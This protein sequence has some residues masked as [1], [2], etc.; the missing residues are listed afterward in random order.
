MWEWTMGKFSVVWIR[1]ARHI[2][3]PR[4]LPRRIPFSK[5]QPCKMPKLVIRWQKW[6]FQECTLNLA[7]P[8]LLYQAVRSETNLG[9]LHERQQRAL[10]PAQN[11]SL[12]IRALG[13][14]AEEQLSSARRQKP[15]CR[16][17]GR[18]SI[19]LLTGSGWGS[20]MSCFQA[21]GR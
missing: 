20:G 21:S 8:G 5:S 3:E 11:F 2:V 6:R 12:N 14:I 16:F 18:A 13:S 19:L 10:S 4:H 1:G 7:N 9:K 15:P 17:R